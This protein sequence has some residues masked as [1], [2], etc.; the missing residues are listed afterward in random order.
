M[1][2]ISL[3]C[4][5]EDSAGHTTDGQKTLKCCALILVLMCRGE[6]LGF[7]VVCG[8][9]DWE[10]VRISPLLVS[11]AKWKNKC[12]KWEQLTS[13]HSLCI[14][15]YTW[16]FLEEVPAPSTWN[17]FYPHKKGRT[18]NGNGASFPCGHLVPGHTVCT[19]LWAEDFSKEASWAWRLVICWGYLIYR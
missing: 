19:I 6:W 7:Q 13:S 2:P 8:C 1:K 10:P 16:V 11:M 4:R 12:A 17:T 9:W 15:L 14:D 5:A 3:Y 18:V